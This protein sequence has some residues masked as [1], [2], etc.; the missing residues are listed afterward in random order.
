MKREVIVTSDGST[1]IRINELN[2]NYHS[3]HGAIQESMH[4]FI[5]NGISK[6]L[7]SNIKVLE[8]GFGTGL[9]ALLTEEF[10][11]TKNIKVEYIGIEAYPISIEE[12][13]QLNYCEKIGE[14]SIEIFDRFHSC[15]WGDLISVSEYFS[16]KKIKSKVEE[17][18][19][20]S[21]FFDIIYFDAFAPD[22]QQKL[23][24]TS[25]FQKMFNLLKNNGVLV[26][27]CAKGQVKR[28]LKSVGFTIVS[29]PGPPGKR[30]MTKA[31]KRSDI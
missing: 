26:T 4:I 20:E 3:T 23:W 27:Y 7:K 5:D 9:N 17:Y 31:I 11:R 12:K 8:I 28:D 2:E 15:L 22:V 1:T 30:E 10:A 29:L 14:R 24:T 13:N 18:V 19:N 21:D 25:I 16:L 6:I